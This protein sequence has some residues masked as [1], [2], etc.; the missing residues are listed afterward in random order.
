M[1]RKG[2]E[3][4]RAT[5]SQEIREILNPNNEGEPGTYREI[6]VLVPDEPQVYVTTLPDAAKRFGTDRTYKLP[7][8]P[9]GAQITFRLLPGQPLF[10]AARSGQA[11]I[12]LIVEHHRGEP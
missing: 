10:A 11:T 6:Q 2:T 3:F 4:H 12:T 5:V 1:L 9:P 8:I 7:P